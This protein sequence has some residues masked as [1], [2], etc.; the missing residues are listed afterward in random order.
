MRVLAFSLLAFFLLTNTLVSALNHKDMAM[1]VKKI[2]KSLAVEKDQLKRNTNKASP[3][4]QRNQM[5]FP[6]ESIPSKQTKVVDSTRAN[7]VSE[8]ER[9]RH[10]FYNQHNST[11]DYEVAIATYEGEHKIYGVEACINLWKPSV[12]RNNIYGYNT[13]RIRIIAGTPHNFE[14]IEV[15][16]HNDSC[17]KTCYHRRCEGFTLYGGGKS[18]GSTFYEV[19]S[20]DGEQCDMFASISKGGNLGNWWL[21]VDGGVR[22]PDGNSHT[23]TKMGSGHF[24]Q[25]GYRKASYFDQLK[26]LPNDAD[27]T[28][29]IPPT[30]LTLDVTKPQ[31]YDI[32]F[33]SYGINDNDTIPGFYYEGPASGRLNHHPRKISMVR[34][35]P[36]EDRPRKI[37]QCRAVR[38]LFLRLQGVPFSQKVEYYLSQILV[39]FIGQ[40]KRLRL[41]HLHECGNSMYD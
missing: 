11:I 22:S 27:G 19:S 38:T 25:R 4:L 1:A 13:A 33:H 32:D 29:W 37:W 16:W 7:F 28:A 20:Y 6:K 24:S 40:R 41:L 21:Q 34:S 14:A 2:N 36:K 26:I 9:K 31:C 3:I 15:G 39:V 8:S 5:K 12:D 10:V 18:R 17:R 23:S 35:S 30:N